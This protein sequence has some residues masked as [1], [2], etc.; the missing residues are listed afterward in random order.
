MHPKYGIRFSPDIYV[1]SSDIL[2][3]ADNL[4]SRFNDNY[5]YDWEVYVM[6]NMKMNFRDYYQSLF[7]IMISFIK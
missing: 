2:F 7:I 6:E 3:N 5:I 4:E 1:M